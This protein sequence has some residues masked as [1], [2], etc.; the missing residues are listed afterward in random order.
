MEYLVIWLN[1]WE[2]HTDE[3]IRRPT[4]FVQLYCV[5]ENSQGFSPTG[6]VL[7]ISSQLPFLLLQ[8]LDQFLSV[9]EIL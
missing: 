5:F 6:K 3:F 9:M 4:K 8:V 7:S 2:L 1:S